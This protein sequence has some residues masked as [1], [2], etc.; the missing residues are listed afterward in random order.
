MRQLMAALLQAIMPQPS[1]G[2]LHRAK[3]V[4]S[5]HLHEPP[6]KRVYQQMFQLC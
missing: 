1:L 5:R 6:R 3:D 4:L 2:R